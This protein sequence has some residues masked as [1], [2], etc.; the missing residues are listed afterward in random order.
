[1]SCQTCHSQ[2]YQNCGS[3]HVDTGVRNGPFM[4]FKIGMNPLPGVKRFKY[5]VLR[6]APHAPDTWSNYGVSNLVNFASEPTWRHAT[7]HNIKR[8]TART[9][10]QSGQG[11]SDACHI[12]NGNNKQWFLFT[13]DLGEAWEKVANHGVVVDG[14]LPAS[15]K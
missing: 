6:N 12:K 7:P 14:K 10:V 5:V 13:D 3:C 9:E 1:M 11:C 8:W 4:D 2:D 15:W